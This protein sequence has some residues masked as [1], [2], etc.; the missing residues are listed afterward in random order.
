[1]TTVNTPTTTITGREPRLATGT[2]EQG[3]QRLSLRRLGTMLNVLPPNAVALD[4]IKEMLRSEEFFVRYNAAKLLSKR[5]DRDARLVMEDAL[6]N[7]QPRTRASVISLRKS[8]RNL[9]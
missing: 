7:G 4:A 1:M 9:A 8:S 5:A 2:M 6:K 3:K